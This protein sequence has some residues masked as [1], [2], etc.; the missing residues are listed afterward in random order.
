MPDEHEALFFPLAN[1]V[2]WKVGVVVAVAIIRAQ[3]QSP[4]DLAHAGG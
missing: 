1:L 3:F 4:T 2:F